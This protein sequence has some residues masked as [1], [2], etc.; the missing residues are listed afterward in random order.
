MVTYRRP[1][2]SVRLP[3]SPFRS[4]TNLPLS[5]S[6]LRPT[7][8]GSRRSSFAKYF[9]PLPFSFS[10]FVRSF[11]LSSQSSCSSYQSYAVQDAFFP[12]RPLLPER[13]LRLVSRFSC[14]SRSMP[15]RVDLDR[16]TGMFTS[17]HVQNNGIRRTTAFLSSP[18][19]SNSTTPSCNFLQLPRLNVVDV[20]AHLRLR[21]DQRMVLEHLDVLPHRSFEVGKL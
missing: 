18:Q 15:A 9:S 21:K 10:P 5:C 4:L 1:L 17:L 13:Q 3:L 16:K 14:N 20:P 8:P 6:T 19:P 12:L 2:L 11:P 7:S